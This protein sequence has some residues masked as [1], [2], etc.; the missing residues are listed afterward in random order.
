MP[1]LKDNNPITANGVYH[2]RVNQTGRYRVQA[3][4]QGDDFD[5]CTVTVQQHGLAYTDLNAATAKVA[6]EL[7]LT[8]GNLDVVVASVGASTSVGIRIEQIHV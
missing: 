4:L 7:V 8:E 1:D 3:G 6:K 5:T 2:F